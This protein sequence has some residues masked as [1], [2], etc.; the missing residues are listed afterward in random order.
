MPDDSLIIF[1]SNSGVHKLQISSAC[2]KVVS[3][4]QVEYQNPNCRPSLLPSPSHF[5]TR[6][7]NQPPSSLGLRPDHELVG[8]IGVLDEPCKRP[9]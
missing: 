3:A 2:P 7:H 6:T 4:D 9:I 5:I 8:H 1:H